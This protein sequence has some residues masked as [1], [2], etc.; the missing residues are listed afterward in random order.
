VTNLEVRKLADFD[1]EAAEAWYRK[2]SPNRADGV[3]LAVA[4]TVRGILRNPRLA[5]VR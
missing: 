2:E 5:R 3:A 1:I 4:K